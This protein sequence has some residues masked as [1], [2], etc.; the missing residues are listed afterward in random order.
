MREIITG[1][2]GVFGPS[3]ELEAVEESPS[4]AEFVALNLSPVI[5][6]RKN[7]NRT[8]QPI[9]IIRGDLET[10]LKMFY[11]KIVKE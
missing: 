9:T 5:D 4:Q 3:G 6:G 8:I 11:C 10:A 7:L 2:V 1:F